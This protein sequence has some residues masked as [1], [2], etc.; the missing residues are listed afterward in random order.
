MCV[1]GVRIKWSVLFKT[2]IEEFIQ[3]RIIWLDWAWVTA[4]RMRRRVQTTHHAANS[5]IGKDKL[6]C[7]PALLLLSPLYSHTYSC[8]WW[9]MLSNLEGPVSFNSSKRSCAIT[10]FLIFHLECILNFQ[11]F[12]FIPISNSVLF[13]FKVY[14]LKKGIYWFF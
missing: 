11:K 4:T 8:H 14:I 3:L 1:E 2:I 9:L 5:E 6:V 7:I 12:Y 10:W 13:Q